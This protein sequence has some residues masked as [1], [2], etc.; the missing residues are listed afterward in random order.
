MYKFGRN[1]RRIQETLHPDLIA[2]TNRVI[3][4][5]DISIIGGYRSPEEQNR[6]YHMGMTKLKGGDSKHNTDPS[7]A[8]DIAPYIRSEGIP[9]KRHEQFYYMSGIVFAHW[10]QMTREGV[11]KERGTLLRWGGNWGNYAR[12][13]VKD[14]D[15]VMGKGTQSFMDLPHF[16][17]C[18]PRL[19]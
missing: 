18:S 8:V 17:L 4:D 15:P 11:P 10:K 9:W 1:S 13:D 19:K 2:L 5:I 14:N 12:H 6:L 3:K 7:R 16:E